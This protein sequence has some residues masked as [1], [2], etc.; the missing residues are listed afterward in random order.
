MESLK[1]KVCIVTG[2]AKG[3]GKAI[4]TSLFNNGAIVY[5]L[6]LNI[7]EFLW[8]KDLDPTH[9]R[10]VPLECDICNMTTVKNIILQIKRQ[11]NHIDVLVNNAGIV[12][13]EYLS[14]ID[15]E[16]LR[17]MFEVNVFSLIYIT[18]L[19]SRVMSNQK[20]GS[21]INMASIVGVN[22]AKGQLS[23]SASKGAVISITKSAA[24]ELAPN[25]IRVNALAPGMV[26][27]ER[28]KKVLETQF[29]EKINDI[30]FGRLAEPQEIAQLVT[31]LAS[32]Q[33]QYITGQIIGIDG[34]AIV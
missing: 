19:V 24:K 22:G 25:N 16:K 23:Y 8:T 12:T 3:I 30:P 4:A 2:A 7:D 14:M 31:F 5:M 11:Q 26:G 18:S 6:D 9:E 27:T 13:Y 32:D 28:F 20:S 10:L 29:K 34:G 15:Y 33:S 1:D 21:I 17:K